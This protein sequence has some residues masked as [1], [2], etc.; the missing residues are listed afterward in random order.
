M[1][2]RV[3]YSDADG[4]KSLIRANATCHGDASTST[5]R[6][7]VLAISSAGVPVAT[8]HPADISP[9]RSHSSASAIACVL[10]S[11]VVP[12]WARSPI[13]LLAEVTTRLGI[14]AAG[15]LVEEQQARVVDDRRGE[16]GA[17]PQAGRQRG[18]P[19]AQ[20]L[21]VDRELGA[22]AF[23]P[24]RRDILVDAGVEVEVLL[25]RELAVEREALGHVTNPAA[26]LFTLAP[27]V[28][29]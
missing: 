27:Q 23:D 3:P 22:D 8:S 15:G 6:I 7:P 28:E 24:T 19:R 14:H 21:G 10:T 26:D 12:E 18:H 25:H 4:H 11:T 16:R 17:L 9:T 1:C 5:M 13:R 2:V 29:A 20:R